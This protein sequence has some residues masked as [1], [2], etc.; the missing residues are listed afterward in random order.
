M[1]ELETTLARSSRAPESFV[2]AMFDRD[3]FKR[4]ND[5]KGHPAGGLIL[6]KTAAALRGIVRQGDVLGRYG[7]DEF[8]LVAHGTL[9]LEGALLQRATVGVLRERSIGISAGGGP[10]SAGRRHCGGTDRHRGRSSL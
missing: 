1:E 2:V 3:G 6:K 8:L 10:L 4:V 7:G 9:A 5:E